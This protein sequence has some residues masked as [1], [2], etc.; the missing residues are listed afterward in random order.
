M[1]K[2]EDYKSFCRGQIVMVQL[3][4]NM[5]MA[6]DGAD[7]IEI[8]TAPTVSPEQWA[9]QIAQQYTQQNDG[10]EPTEG[11]LQQ[12]L[13]QNPPPEKPVMMPVVIGTLEVKNE[14]L[15]VTYDY[16]AY[17]PDPSGQARARK[18]Q[19]RTSI[20]PD[21]VKHVSEVSGNLLT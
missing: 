3:K 21:D 9:G 20:A 15:V 5:V 10:K 18:V 13:A 4:D 19:V 16:T 14:L 12:L 8:A 2:A 1:M 7:S 6:A 17:E 11:E